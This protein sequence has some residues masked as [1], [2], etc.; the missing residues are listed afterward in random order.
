MP[1]EYFD[2]LCYDIEKAAG[3]SNFKNESYLEKNLMKAVQKAHLRSN[4][5]LISKGVKLA[6]TIRKIFWR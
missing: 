1:Q 3:S 2:S 4:G 6:I 5:G